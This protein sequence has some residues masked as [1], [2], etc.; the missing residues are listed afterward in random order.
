MGRKKKSILTIV[1]LVLFITQ[2]VG[3]ANRQMDSSE[4]K[5]GELDKKGKEFYLAANKLI[6]EKKFDEVI[7]LS[8]EYIKNNPNNAMYH[9]FKGLALVLKYASSILSK[10]GFGKSKIRDAV[11]EFQIAQN[12]DPENED[13]ALAAMV[14]AHVVSKEIEKA[15]EIF[16]PAIKKYPESIHLNYVGI[17]YYE[18]MKDKS[19]SMI[20]RNFVA[21]NNPEYN[22]RPVFGG[23]ALVISV[24][25]LVK[26]LTT[27]III[28]YVAGFKTGW[29]MKI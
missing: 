19:N 12:L 7:T 17:K 9:Q 20:C 25:T 24:G 22:G 13:K 18:M 3:S 27:A 21:E 11:S 1:V 4:K 5:T 29:K 16:E 15:K 6:D 14:L 26:V 2:V 8:D 10:I 28:S 23:V